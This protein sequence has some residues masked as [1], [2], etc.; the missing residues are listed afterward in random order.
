MT[1]HVNLN[2]TIIYLLV[3]QLRS[4]V[5]TKF[6]NFET[7]FEYYNNQIKSIKDSSGNNNSNINSEETI[8]HK[9]VEKNKLDDLLY[10]INSK[11]INLSN[12]LT[13]CKD[14]IERINDLVNLNF[15]IP[16]IYGDKKDRTYKYKNLR[17][18]IQVSYTN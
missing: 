6:L 2:I 1:T 8:K 7:T 15:D 4:Y 16:G 5:D 14:K 9:E 18:Y 12:D 3:K 11:I 13:D 10:K 17:E